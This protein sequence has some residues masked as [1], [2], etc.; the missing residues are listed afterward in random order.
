MGS[1][2]VE[3]G[4]SRSEHGIKVYRFPEAKKTLWG[5]AIKPGWI[6]L[7]TSQIFEVC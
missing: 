6:P 4:K 7:K 1:C 2:R 3:G 5:N